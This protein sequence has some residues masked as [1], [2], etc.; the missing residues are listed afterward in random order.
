[1]LYF[2][3]ATSHIPD[4]INDLFKEN[5]CFYKLIHP[6]LTVYC[7]SL[8]ITTNKTFEDHIKNIENFVFSIK[9][10]KKLS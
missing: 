1:M 9:I 8:E 4:E 3:R 2:D 5:K 6:G 10:L 7:K